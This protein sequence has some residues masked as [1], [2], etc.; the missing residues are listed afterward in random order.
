MA[1]I[2][3]QTDNRFAGAG[4]MGIYLVV[5]KGSR[6]RKLAAAIADIIDT[7]AGDPLTAVGANRAIVPSPVADALVATQ[8]AGASIASLLVSL[9]AD[10]AD[11]LSV[12][13]ASEL[14]RYRESTELDIERGDGGMPLQRNGV[15]WHLARTRIADAWS[16]L[17]GR[18][19]IPWGDLAI[20]QVD[21]GFTEHPALGFRAGA[22]PVIDT[23][24]DWNFFYAE[25]APETDPWPEVP[26]AEDSARDPLTGANGGHGTRTC[27]VL[28]AHDP[29]AGYYGAAPAV[30]VI[31]VRLSNC[32]EI[33]RDS[34]GLGA[35][36]KHL[37]DSGCDVITMSMGTAPGGIPP[38]GRAQLRRAY[39]LG[40]IVCCA[41]GNHV[42]LVVAPARDRYT[43]AVAGSAPNDEPWISSAFGPQVDI[44]APAWPIRRGSVTLKKKKLVYDYGLGD[45]T[46]FAAPQ[47]A[48]TA[49]M[50]LVRHGAA[51]DARYAERWK[52]VEAFRTLLRKTADTVGGSWDTDNYGAGI[53]DAKSLLE[54]ALPASNTLDHE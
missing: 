26:P 36:L 12:E 54:A 45:G 53:L 38:D 37:I 35:A 29:A 13:R 15:D 49:A 51:I 40:I 46:S 27:T 47:V 20:G 14:L 19:A 1:M 44:A 5:A 28:A 42:P 21:T 22:T 48:A 18:D 9:G 4:T 31:P 34:I 32:V 23:G 30:R 3:V 43:I 10:H 39:D 52:R 6:M 33:G 41:A 7:S 24:L 2:V 16:L 11:A 50:W 17:G 8:T 25:T